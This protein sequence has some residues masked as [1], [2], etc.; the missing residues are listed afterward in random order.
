MT[1]KQRLGEWGEQVAVD[2]LETHGY[3]IIDRRVHLAHGEIDIVA[4]EGRTLVFVEV[5]T[6]RSNAYGDPAQAI[7]RAKAR[8]L[9]L[10]AREYLGHQM[11]PAVR[12]DVVAI[13]HSDGETPQVELYKNALDL[14]DYLDPG[15]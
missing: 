3:I 10:A 4:H 6:R 12:F 1:E 11:V 7:T 8:H 2:Y 9:A 15:A 5:K 13:L 14:G